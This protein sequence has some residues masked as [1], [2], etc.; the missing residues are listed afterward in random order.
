[1]KYKR[2]EWV[3]DLCRVL[4]SCITIED[5]LR[6]HRRKHQLDGEALFSLLDP[7]NLGY[8]STNS[9]RTWLS[10]ECGMTITEDDVNLFL[11]RHD[12]DRDYRIGKDE[13][14]SEV[15]AEEEPVEEE[16]EQQEEVNRLMED[17][18]EH[19]EVK[20]MT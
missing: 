20:R 4:E 9:L 15:L 1:M 12:K 5:I 17:E 10:K 18:E 6:L 8:F 2:T 7:Y 19:L 16:E 14:L 13:F 3:E 11:A